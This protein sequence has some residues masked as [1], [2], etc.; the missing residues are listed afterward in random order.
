MTITYG[1]QAGTGGD[2]GDILHVLHGR[3]TIES[4]AAYQ[5]LGWPV[6]IGHRQRT[7]SGCTCRT[8]PAAPH[9]LTPGA[10]PVGDTVVPLHS[11]D[12]TAAFEAA[13]GA[14]VIIACT[15][16]DALVVAHAIGMGVML[17]A[18]ATNLHIPCLTAGHT[19]ATL[20]VEP[21]T[22]SLLADC[23]R[24][25]VRSGP[26]SWVAMPPSYGIRWDT[27]PD[28]ELPLP[29]AKA[30]RPHLAQVLKLSLAARAQG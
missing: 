18:D 23:P 27:A 14:G 26:Q 10:H 20:F 24:V 8:D 15:H 17:R 2:M 1:S 4:A 5:R 12:L 3:D 22:G 7:G 6:A 25:D 30:V 11:G 28:D 13:P 9:C 21:G 19:T 29:P 16:F